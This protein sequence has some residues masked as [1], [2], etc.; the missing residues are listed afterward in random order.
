M[1]YV[2]LSFCEI[3]FVSLSFNL[4]YISKLLPDYYQLS[5]SLVFQ[6]STVE[7]LPGVAGKPTVRTHTR[8]RSD[9]TGLQ[10]TSSSLRVPPQD[11]RPKL[12][13]GDLMSGRAFDNGCFCLDARPVGSRN[14]KHCVCGA[15][16]LQPQL[17]FLKVGSVHPFYSKLV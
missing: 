12:Q 3:F 5:F 14:H 17:E 11:L 15:P 10:P 6:A 1:S 4:F 13:L 2:N 7:A 16:R 8:S 9:A